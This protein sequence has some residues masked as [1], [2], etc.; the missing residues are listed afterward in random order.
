LALVGFTGG[1][2]TDVCVVGFREFEPGKFHAEPRHKITR[3]AGSDILWHLGFRADLPE[4][5]GAVIDPA[6]G[7]LL[8]IIVGSAGDSTDF[9]PIEFADTLLS[10]VFIAR[11]MRD[12]DS[13]M[14]TKDLVQSGVGWNYQILNSAGSAEN[15]ADFQ[16]R[17]FLQRYST[18]L[19][20]S[21]V[22]V[23]TLL[24]GTDSDGNTDISVQTS[25]D[26]R[27]DTL[28]LENQN[29]VEYS[30]SKYIDRAKNLGFR[31]IDRIRVSLI[32]KFKRPAGHPGN[33]EKK[34]TVFEF[35][36]FVNLEAGQSP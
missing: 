7:S 35:Q 20:I 1:G 3:T 8:G 29:F 5:G 33:D 31:S 14:A 11:I 25:R 32:P 18:D 36:I 30:A 13:L 9:L 15:P 21:N 17:F 34:K 26:D 4:M 6:D 28:P 16:I 22:E 2:T 23:S 27:P 19:P 12:M 24:W 10:Q